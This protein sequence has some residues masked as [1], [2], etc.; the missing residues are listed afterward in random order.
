[1]VGIGANKNEHLATFS[2]DFF[3]Q[4]SFFEGSSKRV[5]FTRIFQE[6][7]REELNPDRLQKAICEI[8][9]CSFYSG[10]RAGFERKPTRLV[11]VRDGISEGQ[12]KMA[13]ERELQSI[14]KG[15][16][17]G[18]MSVGEEELAAKG[19]KITFVIATKRHSKR[20]FRVD[21]NGHVHNTQPG[22]V[23]NEGVVRKD[24]V[25]ETF[26][27]THNAIK[28][29]CFLHRSLL[30][31]SQLLLSFQGTAQLTQYTVLLND[32]NIPMLKI[33]EFM[34]MLSFMH[35]VS[36]CP[37]SLPLPVYLVSILFRFLN[38]FV[39][40]QADETGMVVLKPILF[41]RS[42]KRSL[43]GFE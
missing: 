4:V 21:D 6:S 27:Q 13:M 19:P 35:Q 41:V 8:I 10:R 15:Y 18:M 24:V 22:D 32:M 39:E 31:Y 14:Y 37:T 2:A 17:Q 11:I 33:Q 16:E 26:F 34:L 5:H 1:M 7:C 20:F 42:S 36:A 28:A 3:Y 30:G 23:V 29:S 9:E 40:L 43:R 38:L 12:Y 25:D